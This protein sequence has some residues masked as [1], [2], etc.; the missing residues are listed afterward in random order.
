[1]LTIDI[2]TEEKK[3]AVYDLFDSF[4]KKGDIYDYFGVSDSKPVI[5]YVN[6]VAE[7]IGFDFSV[8]KNKKKKYC[9]NCGKELHGDQKKFCSSSCSATY[10]NKKR[11]TKDTKQKAHVTKGKPVYQKVCERCGVEFTT[12]N[13][14]K[15]YCSENCRANSIKEET[16]KS[17]LNGKNHSSGVNNKLPE[18]IRTYLY[19]R[20]GYRCEI[21]GFSGYNIKTGKTILQI[22]HI[23]GNSENTRSENL[24]V[25]CPNC[26]AMTDNY[27]GLNKGKS[28]RRN[29]YK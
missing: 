6:E 10:N 23:D 14:D 25:L 29:R 20:A 7:K 5:K 15:R 22:H 1:M 16:V 24:Q 13:K 2:S 26:H 4:T 28:T 9:L 21:C 12:N 18:S 3:Q 19:E 17:W 8:Y 27:M 11:G